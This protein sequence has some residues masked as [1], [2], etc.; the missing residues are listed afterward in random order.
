MG[1]GV[2]L[3]GAVAA[4]IRLGVVVGPLAGSWRLSW[5]SWAVLGCPAGVLGRL[6]GIL[7]PVL[8]NLGRLGRILGLLGGIF[9]PSWTVLAAILS[10]IANDRPG[11]RSFPGGRRLGPEA[12]GNL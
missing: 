6:G 11:L 8:S 4:W 3:G 2:S 9:G 12:T 7:E 5:P 1:S 10:G